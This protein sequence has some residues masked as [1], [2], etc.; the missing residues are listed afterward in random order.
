VT[1]LIQYRYLI[2]FKSSENDFLSPF[3][4]RTPSS[5]ETTATSSNCCPSHVTLINGTQIRPL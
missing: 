4:M 3:R 5:A 2:F 1:R